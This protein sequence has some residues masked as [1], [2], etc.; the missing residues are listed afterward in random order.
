MKEVRQMLRCGR[1]HVYD[2]FDAGVLIG[3]KDLPRRIFGWSI[4]GHIKGVVPA[5]ADRSATVSSRFEGSMTKSRPKDKAVARM[6]ASALA[7][8]SCTIRHGTLRPTG[9]FGCAK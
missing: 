5:K 1:Q 2:L 8:I 4:P 9:G 6:T 7:A 3:P